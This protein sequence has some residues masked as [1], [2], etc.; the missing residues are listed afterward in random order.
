MELKVL[1]NKKIVIV[2]VKKTGFFRKGTGL[3]FRTRNTDNLLFDFSKPVTWQGDLT[4]VFVFFSF[5]TLWLDD[6]NKVIDFKIIRPFK[7]KIRQKNKF[8][9]IIELPFNLSNRKLIEKFIGKSEF[10]RNFPAK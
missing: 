3:T 6:K 9:R 1:F 8:Y 5:L 10:K 2:P 7:L 4:S